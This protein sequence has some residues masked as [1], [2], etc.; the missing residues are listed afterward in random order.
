MECLALALRIAPKATLH[1]IL[2]VFRRCKSLL[3]DFLKSTHE[4]SALYC[5]NFS[6][7]TIY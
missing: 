7:S 5:S 2:N 1:E 4:H 3:F 6:K